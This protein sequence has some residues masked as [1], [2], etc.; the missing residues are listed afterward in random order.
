MNKGEKNE[1]LKEYDLFLGEIDKVKNAVSLIREYE[2]AEGYYLAFSGG[3]DSIVVYELLKMS[4]VKFD[5]HFSFTSVDPPHLLRFIYDN[6]KDVKIE[7]PKDT[8]WSLIIENGFPPTRIARYCCEH[9]KEIHGLG[10]IVATGIR[11]QESKQRQNRKII[12]DCIYHKKTYFHPIID[13]GV[14]DV[15]QFIREYKMNYCELYDF[16]WNRIGCI[17]CP[18]AY[19]KQRLYEFNFYPKFMK[20]Y[21]RTFREM[22]KNRRNKPKWKDE[23]DVFNWWISGKKSDIC[24]YKSFLF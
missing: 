20:A 10:R 15:W 5:S 24:E 4:G 6:Y 2:P 21:L 23:I 12:E 14:D 8:M 13:W 19:K 11:R 7:R 9:L 16:G 18:M 17:G 1:M 3:K 22:L